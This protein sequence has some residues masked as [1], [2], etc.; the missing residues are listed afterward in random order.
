[1]PEGLC[2]RYGTKAT[3]DFLFHLGMRIAR[4]ARWLVKGARRSVTKRSTASACP[5]IR[6]RGL[7]ATDGS[8]LFVGQCELGFDFEDVH[9]TRIAI[10]LSRTR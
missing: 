3:A 9:R 2:A 1:M 8:F 5:R 6:L 4:S 7:K 10:E